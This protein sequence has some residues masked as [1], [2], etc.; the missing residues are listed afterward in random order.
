M[1]TRRCARRPLGGRASWTSRRSAGAGSGRGRRRR[2]GRRYSGPPPPGPGLRP[3]LW[4]AM[5]ISGDSRRFFFRAS[6][7]RARG[8]ICC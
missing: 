1:Q 8:C 3:P 5:P 6:K 2:R 4:E 7:L